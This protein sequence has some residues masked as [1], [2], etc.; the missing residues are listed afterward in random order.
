MELNIAKK[1]IKGGID[2]S[3][4]AQQW[5]DL[6]AGD[7]LFTK[8]LAELLPAGSQIIAIDKN[9]HALKSISLTNVS[10]G[11]ETL[12]IDFNSLPDHLP[13]LDGIV[14]ANALHYVKDQIRFLSHIRSH[15][16]KTSGVIVVVEYDL[17]KSNPW[18]PY[19]ISKK[20]LAML[21]EQAEFN[22]EVFAESVPSKLN[23]SEI[24]SAV[25]K[26]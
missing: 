20:R 4:P 26:Q 14:M 8:A 22:V 19:P 21:A 11:L 3:I 1:L 5:V 7:G 13:A 17:E 15:F 23:S 16:L 6:G 10:I 9:S 25:L 12:A 24:Y 2:A 18:V